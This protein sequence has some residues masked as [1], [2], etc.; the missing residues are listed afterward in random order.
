M[1]VDIGAIIIEGVQIVWGSNVV[2]ISNR[3]IKIG[4]NAQINI[5]L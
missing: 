4:E 1:E 2:V 5:D 3:W